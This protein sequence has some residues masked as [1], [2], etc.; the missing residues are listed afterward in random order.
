MALLEVFEVS[1]DI[2]K[3]IVEGRNAVE[4]YGK[5]RENGY[6]TMKEDGII[7]MLDGLTTLDEIR[8]V[9]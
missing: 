1:E 6:L 9:L 5:A 3:M 7:K 8:R 4:I 2:K